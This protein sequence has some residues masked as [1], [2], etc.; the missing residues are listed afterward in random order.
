MSHR[1][2][3]CAF[4]FTEAETEAQDEMTCPCSHISQATHSA[5]AQHKAFCLWGFSWK[6]SFRLSAHP[7][8]HSF[9]AGIF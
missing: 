2:L 6:S 7:G 8:W 1:H 5:W 4:I 9:W 3:T